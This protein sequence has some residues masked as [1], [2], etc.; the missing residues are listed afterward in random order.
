MSN[1]G[2][3]LNEVVALCEE[4]K[5]RGVRWVE[6]AEIR[7]ANGVGSKTAKRLVNSSNRII[8][9]GDMYFSRYEYIRAYEDKKIAAYTPKQVRGQLKPKQPVYKEMDNG[10]KKTNI[11]QVRP[12]KPKHIKEPVVQYI[13]EWVKN[14]PTKKELKQRNA[15]E[16]VVYRFLDKD[17][18]IIY[19]GR[20]KNLENRLHGHNHLPVE[21]YKQVVKI[22]FTRFTSEDDLDLAEPYYIAKWKPEFNQD[23]KN[24]NYSFTIKLLETKAW[25]N[26]KHVEM[27]KKH[28]S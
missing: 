26:Y 23:F 8:S 1:Q 19:V 7:K 27:V 3:F 15:I 25:E 17:G 12:M 18:K 4:R 24:K 21:C 11:S 5:E 20:A 16:H 10:F 28:V 6:I 14:T 22:E 2:K 13:P 9:C